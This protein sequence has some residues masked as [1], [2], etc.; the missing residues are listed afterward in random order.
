MIE[1]RN[2]T[3]DNFNE[4]IKLEVREDQKGFV[5][6]NICSLAQAYV[7]LSNNDCIPMPYAIYADDVMI[8]FI[9]LSY[10]EEDGDNEKSYGVW[11]FMID[12]EHQGKGYGREAMVKALE[13]IKTF[14]HGKAS[15]VYISYELENEAAK[16]LYLSL[17]FV[18]T[19]KVE[20]GEMVSKLAL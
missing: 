9:M 3:F 17:G 4:C 20:E 5:A 11:R 18:E 10:G 14:P 2:I 13:L 8:G 19:G 7:A 12:K 1:L 16:A 6:T 15:I